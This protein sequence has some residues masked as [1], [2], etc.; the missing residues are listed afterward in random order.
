MHKDK[1]DKDLK[2]LLLRQKQA[3]AAYR[4]QDWDT[5]ERE[6]F[7]LQQSNP[8][9]PVYG[10]YLDRITYFRSHPPVPDWDGVFTFK[11]K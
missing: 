9:R 4:K 5:A 1:V 3:L 11:T 8:G 10:M 2:G 6:F 7:S